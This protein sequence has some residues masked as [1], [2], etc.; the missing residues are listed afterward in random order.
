M[1]SIAQARRIRGAR[2]NPLP[3]V[4]KAFDA[5]DITLRR[6]QLAVIAGG[7]GVGKSTVALTLA[8][9]SG[10]PT[11]YFSPD[12]DA[13]IQIARSYSIL[14]GNPMTQGTTY[15]SNES[16]IEVVQAPIRFNFLAGPTFFDIENSV[17]AFE[18]L[19]G[20]YPHLIVIDNITN[21][22]S[23]LQDNDTDPFSGLEGLLDY[24]N[25]MARET[26][27]CV[28]G[29]HHVTGQ[30]NDNDRP[31]PLS[32][33]KGQVGRTPR[34]ILTVHKQAG[35]GGQAD[36]LRFSMVKNTGGR[37]DASGQ[38]FAELEFDGEYM[39]IS[40][41]SD[42]TLPVSPWGMEEDEDE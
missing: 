1:Y 18:E 17:E 2:G 16:S 40:D 9:K 42:G 21:V 13:S 12:S 24:C 23:G 30:Y 7:P 26:Q 10:T 31:I 33:V 38:S 22:R 6:G 41:P 28:L 36:L 19:Y 14:T 15:A 5:N 29:L 3:A 11:L 8:L 32:G 34:L 27:A 37:A 25:T 39:R 20:E 35:Y 4:F